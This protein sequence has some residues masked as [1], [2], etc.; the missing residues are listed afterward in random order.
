M[1]NMTN[2]GAEKPIVGRRVYVVREA[3]R[4]RV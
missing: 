4:A 3:M 2:K 1:P